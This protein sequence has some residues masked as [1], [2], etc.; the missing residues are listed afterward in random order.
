MYTLESKT[1]Q[2][3]DGTV[4]RQLII[5]GPLGIASVSQLKD[6][7]LAVLNDHAH[8]ILNMAA[9]TDI[10][11]SVLQLLCSA[12]KYAQRH[13]KRF[14]LQG[15]CTEALIDRAQS[16]GFLRDHACSKVEDPDQ[17]LWIPKNLN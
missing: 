14:Q 16:L 3:D 5:S 7:L 12:N 8:V 1:I 6:D 17:C 13:G 9:V 11:Y 4:C 2:N 10:D 15:Q